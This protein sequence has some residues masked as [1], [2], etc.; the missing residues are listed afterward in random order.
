[1]NMHFYKMHYRLH[2]LLD[3]LYQRA[4]AFERY[5]GEEALLVNKEE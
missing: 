4:E 3:L 5:G 1:M 2:Q